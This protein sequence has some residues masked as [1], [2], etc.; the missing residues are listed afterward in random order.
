MVVLA[1]KLN[2]KVFLASTFCSKS[3]LMRLIDDDKGSRHYLNE[4]QK[5]IESLS[6]LVKGYFYYKTLYILIAAD[7]FTDNLEKSEKYVCE[8]IDNFRKAGY[9]FATV[10]SMGRL[11]SVYLGKSF[12]EPQY[13]DKMREL[14]QI[15]ENDRELIEK[16]DK[17]KEIWILHTLGKGAVFLN[18]YY[19]AT[20]Y[21]KKVLEVLWKEKKP[22]TRYLYM[23]GNTLSYLTMIYTF[24]GEFEKALEYLREYEKLLLSEEFKRNINTGYYNYLV[25]VMQMNMLYI[26]VHKNKNVKELTEKFLQGFRGAIPNII[27]FRPMVEELEY[28]VVQ[29]TNREITDEKRVEEEK[30]KGGEWINKTLSLLLLA[31]ALLTTGEK[32]KFTETVRKIQESIKNSKHVTKAMKYWA[33]SYEYLGEYFKEKK[34]KKAIKK[35]Q[36]VENKCKREGFKKIALEIK[37]YV[38]ILKIN[39]VKSVN[40][41]KF[42]RTVFIEMFEKYSEKL[43]R[44]VLNNNR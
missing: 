30:E 34:E 35:L 27:M 40:A 15:I 31:Q 14:I 9:Y 24:M 8:C 33:E 36:K 25:N 13:H 28:Q 21:F 20:V 10:K 44:K 3:C 16:V 42:Q 39:E 19:R 2:S 5:I 32:E 43:T 7:K 4:A 37:V 22:D 38:Q 17:C 6:S 23:I 11:L 12:N 41:S 29:K 26:Y 1:N 18:E